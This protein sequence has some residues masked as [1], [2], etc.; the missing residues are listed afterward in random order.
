MPNGV[1]VSRKG[2]P[3]EIA[4]DKQLAF[5]SEWPL[6]P[7]EA[8]G[9]FDV[10]SGSTYDEDIHTHDLGYPPVFMYWFDDGTN[11]YPIGRLIRTNFY[12]N[13]TKLRIDSNFTANT[14]TFHWKI[15]R[16]SLLTD[17][18]SEIIETTDATE[19]DSDD[20]GILVSL[21]GKDISSE[22]KRDFGIRS[23]VRQLMI[24]QS[25]GTTASSGE[26][27]THN[28]GYKPMYWLFV[29]NTNQ[30]PTG[31]Y[32]L[33]GESDDFTVEATTTELTWVLYTPPGL[34]WAYLIFKDPLDT[35]G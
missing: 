14:G 20:Y 26:T 4:S 28:L 11:L 29:E 12:V 2:Y 17:Y 16:R 6:L 8:E 13:D 5:S 21:P 34:K 18:E 35:R 27:I 1:I 24:H 7:I 3:V 19:D 25:D 31:S 23:D 33:I 22:D 15:F 10:T 9:T 30:N 32:S